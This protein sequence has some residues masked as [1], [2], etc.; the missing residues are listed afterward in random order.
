M[1]SLQEMTKAELLEYI[2]SNKSNRGRKEQVLEL[3][4]N[5]FDSIEAIAEELGITA[6]NVS[7]QLTYLRNDGHI[8]I[9]VSIHKESVLM[10]LNK[11]QLEY[12]KSLQPKK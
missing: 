2:N 11:E 6:K 7:S 12:I 10:L 3:L 1:K 4:K 9:T 8:I 5:G